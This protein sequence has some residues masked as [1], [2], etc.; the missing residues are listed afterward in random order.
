MAGAVV[1][2]SVGISAVAIAAIGQSGT[3]KLC[4]KSG[5]VRAIDN[6][7]TC[8]TGERT[9]TVYTKDGADTK[10][11]SKTGKAAN[12]DKLDGKD[13][14]AFVTTNCIGYPHNSIDWHGC[15]LIAANISHQS[16]SGADLSGA[17]LKFAL[18]D[19]VNF[20]ATH[21]ENANLQGVEFIDA[22]L[23]NAHMDGADLTNANM[24]DAVMTGA[25]LPGATLTGVNWDNTTCPDGT[26]STN[27]NSGT[28]EGHLS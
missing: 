9:L 4:V 28:C 11:L 3:F 15:N 21:L 24:K 27:D 1:V 2:L 25:Q 13:S 14:T 18:A 26:N 8:A 20:V 19:G 12:S 22:A 16:M 17:N 6:S 7:L 5:A 10:F 23:E